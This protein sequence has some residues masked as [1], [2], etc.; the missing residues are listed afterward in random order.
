MTYC[1]WAFQANDKIALKWCTLVE[2]S[3]L[4][5]GWWCGS[6]Y[7]AMIIM[8]LKYRNSTTLMTP[9]VLWI[10]ASLVFRFRVKVISGSW[11][12]AGKIGH[13]KWEILSLQ[14]LKISTSLHTQNIWIMLAYGWVFSKAPL[15]H[16]IQVRV[17]KFAS[18]EREGHW[19]NHV[20]ES[21]FRDPVLTS[22]SWRKHSWGVHVSGS[23]VHVCFKSNMSK[24]EGNRT[25]C[26]PTYSYS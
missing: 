24:E 8:I 9:P 17:Q 3:L 25:L 10:L 26:G 15:G 22:E 13:G 19:K 5:D 12:V 23:M 1:C 7:W 14:G 20:G 18:N 11:A 21:V 2:D 16:A 4:K 6:L